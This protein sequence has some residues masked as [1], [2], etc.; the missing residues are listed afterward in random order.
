MLPSKNGVWALGITSRPNQLRIPKSQ[1]R[2]NFSPRVR[3]ILWFDGPFHVSLALAKV[4]SRLEACMQGPRA[5]STLPKSTPEKDYVGLCVRQSV[6]IAYDIVMVCATM[7]AN[8][9]SPES[10]SETHMHQ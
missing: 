5:S 1:S 6:K 9:P 4:H 8:G 7:K 2:Q 3:P 10:F